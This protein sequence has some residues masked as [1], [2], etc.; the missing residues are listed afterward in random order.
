MPCLT[1]IFSWVAMSVIGYLI[2]TPVTTIN[3]LHLWTLFTSFLTHYNILQLLFSLLS[4]IPTTILIENM[5]GTVA[6]ACDVMIKG[7]IVQILYTI[8]CYIFYLLGFSSFAFFFS[9]GLWTVFFL[10]QNLFFSF[11]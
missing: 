7:V 6:L 10:L 3:S 5:I 11:L 8:I 9:S 1:Y 2:N 4:L